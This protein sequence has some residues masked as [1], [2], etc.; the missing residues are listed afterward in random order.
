[1]EVK[2]QKTLGVLQEGLGWV[3]R[4][5]F[6]EFI[7]SASQRS[8]SKEFQSSRARTE[9]GQSHFATKGSRSS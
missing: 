5:N 1:M 3:L 4:I 9:K 8:S 7:E 2:R 6:K